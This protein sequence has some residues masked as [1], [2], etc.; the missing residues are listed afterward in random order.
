[1]L[2]DLSLIDNVRFETNKWHYMSKRW[3]YNIYMNML[4]KNISKLIWHAQNHSNKV[5]LWLLLVQ[6]VANYLL[7]AVNMESNVRKFKEESM[8]DNTLT[9]E[10]T[11][12]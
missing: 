4:N 3:N 9:E 5:K 8:I 10:K 7:M 1:M 11:G 2:L 6:F 12:Q